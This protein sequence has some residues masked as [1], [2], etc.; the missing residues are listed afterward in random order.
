M[1]IKKTPKSSGR[2]LTD[3]ER[4]Q[5]KGKLRINGIYLEENVVQALDGAAER[6]GS[7]R[8]AI[9]LD[10]LKTRLRIK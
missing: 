4:Y 5:A 3:A 1:T 6:E 8:T 9:I 7:S 2:S 10:A